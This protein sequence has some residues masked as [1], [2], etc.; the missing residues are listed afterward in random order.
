MNKEQFNNLSIEEQITYINIELEKTSLTKAC[1][2]IGIDRATVRKRFKSRGYSLVDNQYKATE[3]PIKTVSKEPKQNKIN[4]TNTVNTQ[5]NKKDSK[6]NK[7]AK[8]IKVLSDKVE[9]L[10][11]Q[12]KDLYTMINTITTTNTH[13]I[14]TSNTVNTQ[15]KKYEGDKV[16]RNFKIDKDIQEQFK[17]YCKANAEYT[18]GDIVSSA[19]EQFIKNK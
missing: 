16:S 14:N 17:I 13:S 19:L 11:S 15:L 6:S 1:E 8:D 12:I 2:A 7:E 5:A 4:T 9:R 18:V 10:E 3:E